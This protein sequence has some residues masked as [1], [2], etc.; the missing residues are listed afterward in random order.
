[1]FECFRLSFGMFLN[2]ILIR[3]WPHRKI[4]KFRLS[5][6]LKADGQRIGNYRYLFC[7]YFVVLVSWKRVSQELGI[8]HEILKIWKQF[9][10]K[11]DSRTYKS[12]LELFVEIF[13]FELVFTVFPGMCRSDWVLQ[14][15]WNF[16]LKALKT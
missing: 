7:L 5:F 16:F 3:N 15:F 12:M 1:M 9:S 2:L 11:I 13:V 4:L 10:L 8:F 14:N 6:A